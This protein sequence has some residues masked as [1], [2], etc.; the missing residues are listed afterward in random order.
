MIHGDGCL[1]GSVWPFTADEYKRSTSVNGFFCQTTIGDRVLGHIYTTTNFGIQGPRGDVGKKQVYMFVPLL[2]ISR[3]TK[4]IIFVHS[5]GRTT[6]DLDD[7]YIEI[8]TYS[9]IVGAH[10]HTSRRQ[11]QSVAT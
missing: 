4:I 11:L 8:E 7:M 5:V 6:V 10:N 3:S 2:V 1:L 9:S